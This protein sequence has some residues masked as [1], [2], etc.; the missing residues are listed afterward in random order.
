MLNDGCYMYMFAE[1]RE[2]YT[3]NVAR[4]QVYVA[5]RQGYTINVARRQVYVARRQGYTINVARRQVYVARRQGGLYYKCCP[6]VIN[7][8]R[9]SY[10][11]PEGYKF[12]P[13]LYIC[14]KVIYLACRLYLN[15]PF[16]GEE[17]SKL[18]KSFSPMKAARLTQMGYK[19]KLEGTHSGKMRTKNGWVFFAHHKNLIM[20]GGGRIAAPVHK[21]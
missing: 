11:L 19:S 4:R 7:F 14:P 13:R 9:R 10:I 18:L 3:I 6:K 1:G 15:N 2:G 17:A 16:M 20:G 5:R 12:R 21:L 8:A